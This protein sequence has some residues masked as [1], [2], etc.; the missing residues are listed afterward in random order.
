MATCSL[1]ITFVMI[2]TCIIVILMKS[3]SNDLFYSKTNKSS[4]YLIFTELLFANDAF[5]YR[6]WGK[7]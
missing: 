5:N 1:L 2:G 7:L 3:E 4:S 6:Q